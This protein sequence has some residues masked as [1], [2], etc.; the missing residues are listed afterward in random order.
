MKKIMFLALAFCMAL[1][2]VAARPIAKHVVLI[3]IDGWGAYSVEKAQNIPDG[4]PGAIPNIR[5]I[6]QRGC[7]TLHSRSVLPSSSAINWASMFMGAPTEVHGYTHWNSRHPEIPSFVTNARGIF[8]TIFSILRDQR[9]DAES[10]CLFEW[11][12]IKYLIDSAAVSH[13][14]QANEENQTELVGKAVSYIKAKKPTFVAVCFDQLDETGHALGHDTPAYYA[15]L[16]RIDGF[17]GQIVEATKAA[18]IYDNTIFIMTADH[19]GKGKGHGGT[20]LAEMQIPFII[21]G[22]GVRAGGA[23]KEVTMQYD[24]AATIAHI[25]G[26]KQPQAWTGR[27]ALQVFK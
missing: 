8:P 3:A 11:D 6:M 5:G 17:V 20:S 19:G 25:L 2:A 21:A 1:T 16:Q 12:G 7:Y 14:E 9:P 18:G 10:G 15:T 13:V 24:T 26:L 23:F 27:P 4:R 22:K